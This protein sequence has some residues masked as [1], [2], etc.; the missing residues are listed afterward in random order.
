MERGAKTPGAMS[1]I[2]IPPTT[3]V[4]VALVIGLM[5]AGLV[6]HLALQPPWL[7]LKLGPNP[8]GNGAIVLAAKGPGHAVPPGTVIVNIAGGAD[9]LALESFDL[10]TEP[11]GMMGDYATYRRFL[12]RQDRLARIQASEEILLTN[13]AGLTFTIRPGRDG[14]PITTLPPDFWVQVAVGLIA[15]LVSAA[16]F[17]FRPGETA[18]RYLLLS[19]LATLVFSPAA[20]VYTTREL[21]VFIL[22]PQMFG[23][24][25]SPVQ[26]YAFLLF[27][28]VYGGLA[29]GILRYR[30]FDLGEWWRRI[31][32][33][34]L[35]VLLLVMLDLFFLLGLHLSSGISLS[36]AL[37]V[38]GAVWLPLR[39]WVWGHLTPRRGIPEE[40]LFGRVIAIALAPPGEARETRWRKLLSAVFDPLRI[41]PGVGDGG[42]VRIA[43]DG[44][45]M[46]MPAIGG[47]PALTLEFAWGG[48]K[49]F[50][51]R[52]A[53]MAYGLVDMLE[54]ALASHASFNN[55]VTE[56]RGRIA[57]D[58][59]DNIAAQ[60]LAALHSSD[61]ER[62]DSTIRDTLAD[63]R[64]MI[65]NTSAGDHCFDGALA[66]LRVE[67]AERLS[68][69]GIVLRW[70]AGADDFPAIHPAVTHAVR[71]IIREAVS[72]VIKHAR[73]QRVDL[74]VHCR[75]GQ[76]VLEIGD[77]GIGFDVASVSTGNGL[78]NIHARLELLGGALDIGRHPA[79]TQLAMRIPILEKSA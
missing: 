56:E 28:L 55:G 19:G 30:L 47:L 74:A 29:F 57:R 79:G 77:D 73:A 17:A 39:A 11:D 6:T 26:G 70:T 61:P 41:E 69:A 72:N 33:W 65:N 16:V 75:N 48:R 34:T 51:P 2:K 78:A 53:A 50:S 59:H 14:R 40:E 76:L 9:S 49:L 68:A 71:S 7:G 60:L 32:V 46:E 42:A 21:A 5:V 8:Q 62:K 52:D 23:V 64:N 58:M 25:T 36:L 3:L 43:R 10:I 44:L 63:L 15:W 54:H 20:A 22:L 18:T 1:N 35:A 27:L 13:A 31:I 4:A 67:S 45:A 37:L 38:C 66:D 12:E 24:D